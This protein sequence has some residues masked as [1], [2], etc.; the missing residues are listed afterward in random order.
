MLTGLVTVISPSLFCRLVLGVDLAVSGPA[1]GPLAGIAMLGMGLAAW[2]APKRAY[3]P[4]RVL[5]ALIA[6]NV[7]ATIYLTYLGAGGLYV[8]ILLWPAVALHA[9]LSVLLVYASIAQAG[10]DGS[11]PD[12][13]NTLSHPPSN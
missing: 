5:R 9:V 6:Y 1:L 4:T 12:G 3:R 10:P 13:A 7:L 2:P 8:G 11:D